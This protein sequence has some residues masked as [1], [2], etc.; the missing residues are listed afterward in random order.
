MP[1]KTFT[2]TEQKKRILKLCSSFVWQS[3]FFWVLILFV[4]LPVIDAANEVVCS[5]DRD[6]LAKYF[7]LKSDPED[8]EAEVC[9]FVTTFFLLSY[10]IFISS[11]FKKNYFF[12]LEQ[13][14][15]KTSL[16]PN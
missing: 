5:I 14:G 2:P 1:F 13:N 10:F 11:C 6:E 4:I 7:S 15:K 12:H 3:F 8:G 16:Q 9:F